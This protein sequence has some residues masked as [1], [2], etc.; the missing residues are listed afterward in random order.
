MDKLLM[1]VGGIL[2]VVV[3]ISVFAIFGGTLVY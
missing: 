2:L 3:F 1:V